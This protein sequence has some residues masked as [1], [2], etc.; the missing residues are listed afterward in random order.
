[1]TR[2][3][4]IT[5]H[6]IQYN[7]PW[8]KILS[9]NKKVVP[10]IFYTWGQTVD[11]EKFDPGFGKKIDWDLPLLEGYEFTFVKNVAA[12]PGTHHFKGIINPTLINEIE[13]WKPDAILVIGWSFKS[14]LQCLRYFKN[15]IPVLFRGDSTLLDEKKGLK[16]LLRRFFLKWVYSFI[17]CAL[18]VGTNNKNYFLK[19]GLKERQLVFAP[20]AIDN[21]RF[22]EP[23]EKY[24]TQAC[25]WKKELG[26]TGNDL[27]LLFAGK[28]EPKKNPFFLLE[29]AKSITDTQLKIILAGNGEL[30]S[31]LKAS[32]KDNRVIFLNF[33]NQQRMPVVYRLA[34]IFIFDRIL[35]HGALY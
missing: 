35:N 3:A 34:D 15:K 2:L 33:Q 4:I 21:D 22:A 17:D 20:H 18:Y 11:G 30:E 9:K 14:H 27:V 19:H 13:Q 28:L 23:N 10:R 31:K 25:E 26:I 24:L 1:M 5:S 16:Q 12:D 32:A 6:P 29:L 8:F 7:A